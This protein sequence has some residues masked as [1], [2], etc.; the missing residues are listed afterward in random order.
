MA[1]AVA[2]ALVVGVISLTQKHNH[3]SQ[4]ATGPEVQ[5]P[6]VSHS[7]ATT[8]GATES[9]PGNR[10]AAFNG[11]YCGESVNNVPLL[12]TVNLS[13]ELTAGSVVLISDD[14]GI[15]ELSQHSF[16]A[17]IDKTGQIIAVGPTTRDPSIDGPI[18]PNKALALSFLTP[19]HACNG[20]TI[21]QGQYMVV[22]VVER[23]SAKNFYRTPD[24]EASL[25][26]FK[27]GSFLDENI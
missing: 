22:V 9:R 23:I 15:P 1:A 2:V 11:P 24:V 5:E 25:G 18:I 12:S 13:Y 4:V 21:T 19:R 3:P 7:F 10:P 14:P 17:V 20:E 16:F 8:G 27:Q 26:A 6:T